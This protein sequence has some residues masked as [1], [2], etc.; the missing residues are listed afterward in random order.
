M[1]NFLSCNDTPTY[2][3]Q[4][5]PQ[6]PQPEQFA[7]PAYGQSS[8]Y[9]YTQTQRYQRGLDDYRRQIDDLV[10]ENKALKNYNQALRNETHAL[11]LKVEK[12][13]QQSVANSNAP[14][15]NE[16]PHASTS[17]IKTTI[18]KEY[19]KQ[20]VD[21]M[22]KNSDINIYG[23]PDVIEK[24]I[25]RNFFN[26]LLNVL[27]HALQTS[28]IRIFNHKVVFDLQPITDGDD[29]DDSNQTIASATINE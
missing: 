29:G 1:G 5:P 3:Q 17:T 18:N 26:L 13:I 25:Y 19:I 2:S 10:R 16:H 21:E 7:N 11:N 8:V 6:P 27:D 23:F 22:L 4:L 15:A 9:D 12:L 24:Q 14:R 20:Y 28:D